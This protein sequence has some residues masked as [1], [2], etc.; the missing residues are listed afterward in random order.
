MKCTL[1]NNIIKDYS[2]EFN[3]LILDDAHAI[4]IC[5]S[6]IYKF[7]KWQ[8]TKIAKLFPTKIMKKIFNKK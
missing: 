5:K 6:C 2:A 8:Q 1:C 7:E 3:H 4:D